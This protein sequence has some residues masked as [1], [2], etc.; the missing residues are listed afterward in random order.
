M[1]GIR[2]LKFPF[3]PDGDEVK[4]LRGILAYDRFER[5]QDFLGQADARRAVADG[6]AVIGDFW[7]DLRPIPVRF[8]HNNCGDNG[9]AGRAG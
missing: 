8:A 2:G 5:T 6:G 4:P 7:Q 1:L 3:R 9:A